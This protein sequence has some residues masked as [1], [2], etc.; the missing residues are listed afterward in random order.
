MPTHNSLQQQHLKLCVSEGGGVLLVHL[1]T[2][3]G[4]AYRDDGSQAVGSV[5]HKLL[6]QSALPAGVGPGEFLIQVEETV[7]RQRQSEETPAH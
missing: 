5:R 3:G 2:A 1:L 6:L 7:Q 4:A